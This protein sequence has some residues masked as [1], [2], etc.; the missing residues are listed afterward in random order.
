MKNRDI[1]NNVLAAL[2]KHSGILFLCITLSLSVVTYSTTADTTSTV[3]IS[4]IQTAGSSVDDEF[5][6][7]YNPTNANINIEGW[8]LRKRTSSGTES[9]IKT[10]SSGVTI[11]PKG[12]F[13]WANTDGI[14]APLSNQTSETS[15]SDNYSIS[16]FNDNDVLIDSITYGINSHPFT[17]SILFPDNPLKNIS[18]ERDTDNNTLIL[19][20]SPTPKNDSFIDTTTETSTNTSGVLADT[21]KETIRINEILPHPANGEEFIELYNFGSQPVNIKDWQIHDAS[22]TGR[23]IFEKDTI[24]PAQDYL[25]LLRSEFS[26][27]LNDSNETLTLL[28]SNNVLIDTLSYSKSKKGLSYN[29]SSDGWRW[30]KILTPNETNTIEKSGNVK[31]KIPKHVYVK[32]P[33]EFSAKTT[34]SDTKKYTWDFDDGH[35]SHIAKPKHT[36][37]KTGTYHV[38][39]TITTDTD[40]TVKTFTIKVKKY[41]TFKLIATEIIPD[42]I[43]KDAK[44]EQLAIQN[45]GKKKINLSGW[46]IATGSSKDTLSNHPIKKNISLKAGE[47]RIFTHN[48]AAFSLPNTHGIIEIRQ[49]NKKVIERITYNKTKEIEEGNIYRKISD[50]SWEWLPNAATENTEVASDTIA[51]ENTNTI[52]KTFVSNETPSKKITLKDLP[53]EE[54]QALETE[55]ERRIIE[56]IKTGAIDIK[57]LSLKNDDD[58]NIQKNSDETKEDVPL[59]TPSS[60]TLIQET[61]GAIRSIVFHFFRD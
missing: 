6:E 1:S 39:L 37:N 9:S 41:P 14:F 36:F 26:F 16:L 24:I 44:N 30:S 4:E 18:I 5:I 17:P 60:Q 49:P 3:I 15:L 51:L 59:R 12:Y 27:A 31:T 38:T 8:Q 32:T 11:P 42:P 40:E 53:D 25:T 13:L 46:S 47:T 50:N 34:S 28:D 57:T 19:Q 45:T 22:K 56:K 61:S 21:S 35:K 10:I 43:G 20:S 54:L 58:I 7:L 48:D 2:Q 55:I 33:V 52:K 29:Y 23:Y